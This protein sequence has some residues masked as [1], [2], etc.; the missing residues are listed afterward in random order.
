[1]GAM[2][3]CDYR[4]V[5]VALREGYGLATHEKTERCC[6]AALQSDGNAFRQKGLLKG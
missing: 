1:M 6:A 2:L 3:P 5:N 4:N